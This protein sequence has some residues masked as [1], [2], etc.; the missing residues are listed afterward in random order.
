MADLMKLMAVGG[1]FENLYNQLSI[2]SVYD[3]H[4]DIM[5]WEERK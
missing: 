1:N 3:F 2:N 5:F 4:S